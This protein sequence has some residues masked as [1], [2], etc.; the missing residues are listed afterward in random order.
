MHNFLCFHNYDLLQFIGGINGKD[1]VEY[2]SFCK[3]NS[4]VEG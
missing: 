1:V 4:Q 3:I 2:I